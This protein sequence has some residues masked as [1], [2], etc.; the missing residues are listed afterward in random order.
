[1]A[2][3]MGARVTILDRSLPRLRTLDVEY[4]GRAQCIFSTASAIEAYAL[5][6]DLLIGAVLVPGAAAPKLLTRDIVRRMRPGSVVVDVAIDQGGCFETSRPTT[7]AEPVFT[8]DGVVHYCVANM[9]GGCARTA[10]MA[11]NNAT[12]PFVLKLAALGL[13]GAIRD[14]PHLARGVN[15]MDGTLTHPAVA[16]SLGESWRAL[17]SDLFPIP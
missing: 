2:V 9:P 7:H 14:D 13:E 15:V 5:D 3:G 4:E 12:L 1:M 17:R 16:A 6:A 8:V 11:L 10:T